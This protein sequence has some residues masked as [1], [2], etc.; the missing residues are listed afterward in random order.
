MPDVVC[1]TT[2]IICLLKI[3]KLDLLRVLYGSIAI[4]EAV[5]REVEQGQAKGYYMDLNAIDWVNVIPVQNKDSLTRLSGLDAGEAE[6]IALA[7]ELNSRLIILDERM[8]RQ[9]ARERGLK[10]T[11]TLGVLLKAKS[12]GFIET[13]AP[14]LSELMV[15]DV[16]LDGRLV[17]EVL[18][19]A[20]ED[21]P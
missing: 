9:T 5:L 1:D 17:S 11:G 7:V 18:K 19:R 15:K 3:G 20:G 2:P 21:T 4:P 8:G 16:W 14:L 13:L 6:A 10:M 12:E